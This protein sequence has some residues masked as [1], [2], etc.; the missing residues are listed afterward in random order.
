[1][2]IKLVLFDECE[3]CTEFECYAIKKLKP[4]GINSVE[5]GCCRYITCKNAKKAQ[6]RL[7]EERKKEGEE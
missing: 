3:F 2:E 6:E 4:G 5:L 7:K 1:M